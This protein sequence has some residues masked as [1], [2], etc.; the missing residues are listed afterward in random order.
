MP[1]LDRPPL[2]LGLALAPGY[3]H[4]ARGEDVPLWTAPVASPAFLLAMKRLAATMRAAGY[5]H[6]HVGTLGMRPIWW[7]ARC[8]ASPA[9][10]AALQ[11]DLDRLVAA[12]AAAAQ[13][14]A[15]RRA[16][17]AAEVAAADRAAAEA[18]LPRLAAL[19]AASSWQLGRALPE[20]AA[21]VR[22]GI[23]D[24]FS[25]GRALALIRN[26]DG[27]RERAEIA[28]R[29]LPPEGWLRL[30]ESADVRAAALEGCRYLSDLDE[31]RASRSNDAGW[32]Q[33][34]TSI[35][36]LLAER[37]E[38]SREETAHAARLLHHHRRQLPAELRSRLF[39]TVP[40]PATA[41]VL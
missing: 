41:P 3:T 27:V 33:D 16:G 19:V 15:A 28:L 9:E 26:A 23:T 1:P 30:A 8:V 34:D 20:A 12:D 29:R 24:S 39:D 6:F 2:A 31:D 7:P 4:H 14:D 38:L 25:V 10:L 40:G 35:G 22:D 13:D 21:L 11:A 32:G 37:E 17:L 36:H 18:A 5:L